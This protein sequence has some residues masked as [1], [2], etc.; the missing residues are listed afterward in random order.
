[1]LSGGAGSWAAAKVA[2]WR[3]PDARRVHVFADTLME[4]D[5]LYRF[6]GEIEGDLGGEHIRLTDGRDPWQVFRDV[7]FLGNTRIDPCSRVLKRDLINSW[8]A[9]NFDPADT[10]IYLG[11]DWT[12]AHRFDRAKE[13]WAPW[14]V[15]APLCDPP[16]QR[17]KGWWLD[18]MI[19]RGIQPPRLYE[20]GFEHNNCGGFCVKAGQGQFAHLLRTLPERYARHE[21]EEESL[22]QYLGKDIAILR[23]RRGGTTK[24]LTMRDFRLRLIAEDP[25]LDLNEWGGCSCFTPIEGDE[26]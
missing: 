9:D 4:D 1:M 21:A 16:F 15:V 6:L 19:A 26:R 11:F 8:L 20:L 7:R 5:D 17:E 13:Y 14:T 18:R 12:E 10:L 2:Q 25:T 3:H 24:P 22:R 23:D